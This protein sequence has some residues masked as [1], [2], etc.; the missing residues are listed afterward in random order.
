MPFQRVTVAA[1]A[2]K[3]KRSLPISDEAL[4]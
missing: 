4:E 3:V 2:I 1:A